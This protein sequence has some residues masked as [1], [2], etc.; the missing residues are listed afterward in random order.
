MS[1]RSKRYVGNAWLD[2]SSNVLVTKRIAAKG[3]KGREWAL[4]PFFQI[5]AVN[6]AP[7]RNPL[8][9]DYSGLLMTAHAMRGGAVL[10][11]PEATA[12]ITIAVPPLLKTEWSS[13]P[14]VTLGAT[15]VA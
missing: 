12:W 3:E 11:A 8:R 15:T 13:L 2:A 1:V 14:S 7:A 10:D 6:G 5:L 4:Q 9:F